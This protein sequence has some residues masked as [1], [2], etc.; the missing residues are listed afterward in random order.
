MELASYDVDILLYVFVKP[1]LL[2]EE[3]SIFDAIRTLFFIHDMASGAPN[4]RWTASIQ[5]SFVQ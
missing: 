3:E 1:A 4:V 2:T 5:P